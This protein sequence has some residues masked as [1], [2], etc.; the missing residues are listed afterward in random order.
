M[1][2]LKIFFSSKV[3][4][5]IF[6][7]LKLLF[8]VPIFCVSIFIIYLYFFSP[9][10]TKFKIAAEPQ[11]SYYSVFMLDHLIKYNPD[12]YK[13]VWESSVAY[14]KRGEHEEGMKRLD[15]AI[16]LAPQEKLGYAG[17]I[18]QT[19]LKDYENALKNYHRLNKL[20]KIVEYPW[21]ENI[22]YLMG[23]SYQG[24]KNYDSA[25]IYYDK[26]I[27]SEKNPQNIYPRTFT[28]RG[29]MEFDQ[30][31]YKKAIEF[32]NKTINLDKN[33]AEAYFYKAQ[34]LEATNQLDSAKYNYQKSLELIKNNYKDKDPY[35]EKFLEIYQLEVEDILKNLK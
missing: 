18:K 13:I 2:K 22:Y 4:R 33:I 35:D 5:I 30:K 10:D 25:N 32:Y 17:W 1:E 24:L 14:N 6:G 27:A 7:T 8:S 23:I 26:F 29:K 19:K 3:V 20:S 34:T 9:I 11:G 31:N 16:A 28:Y 15:K 12:N 21:G